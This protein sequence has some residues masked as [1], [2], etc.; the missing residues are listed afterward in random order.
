[1]VKLLYQGGTL[2]PVLICDFCGLSITDRTKGLVQLNCGAGGKLK[3]DQVYALLHV[4]QGRCDRALERKLKH[5]CVTL[6]LT[7][8][9]ANVSSFE[10]TQVA[11]ETARNNTDAAEHA[12]GERR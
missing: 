7:S 3:N 1:M 2:T 8:F 11:P 10:E 9:M 4:H 5:R 12:Q 6:S